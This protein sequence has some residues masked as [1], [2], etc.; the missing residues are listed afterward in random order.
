MTPELESCRNS[1]HVSQWVSLWWDTGYFQGS[2]AMCFTGVHASTHCSA[3][4]GS[5]G[6]QHLDFQGRVHATWTVSPGNQLEYGEQACTFALTAREGTHIDARSLY[7]W[8]LN[9]LDP[10][11]KGG[12][13]VWVVPVKICLS[14]HGDWLWGKRAVNTCIRMA[15][16][17]LLPGGLVSPPTTLLLGS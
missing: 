9:C 14:W 6:L 2:P 12:G 16:F 15:A 8:Y 1:L 3:K 17:N 7:R 5:V 4:V 11:M 13:D 10:R